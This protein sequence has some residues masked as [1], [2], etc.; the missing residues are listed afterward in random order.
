M[1]VTERSDWNSAVAAQLDDM[2][3]EVTPGFVSV[4]WWWA[5]DLHAM[6]SCSVAERGLV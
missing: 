6:Q 4:V 2:I 3:P 1:T 5:E